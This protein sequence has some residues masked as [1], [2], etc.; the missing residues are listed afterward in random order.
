MCT[1]PA[2]LPPPTHGLPPV[3]HRVLGVT[4]MVGWMASLW[5]WLN[6]QVGYGGSLCLAAAACYAILLMAWHQQRRSTVIVHGML[7]VSCTL[8]VGVAL[9]TGG[10]NSPVLAWIPMLA[11]SALALLRLRR[12]LIW[13]GLLLLI[14]VLMFWAETHSWISPQV[15]QG[16]DGL[17]WAWLIRMQVAASM[18]LAVLLLEGLYREYNHF[19]Q[20][21][22]RELEATQ[23][24]LLKAQTH[25]DE[26]I[27]SVSHELR[28]PM[29]AI[30]GLNQVIRQT[31]AHHPDDVATVTHIQDSTQ[32]LLQVVN[33]ILDYSQLQAGRLSLHMAPLELNRVIENCVDKARHA[34][35]LK[36][37][38]LVVDNQLATPTWVLGD[39]VRLTQIVC[40]TLRNAIAHS[41][42][43]R[44]ALAVQLKSDRLRVDIHDER[45]DMNLIQQLF[46]SDTLTSAQASTDLT[47]QDLSLL[48]AYHLMLLHHG[49]ASA[50]PVTGKGAHFWFDVPVRTTAAPGVAA[51]HAQP[52]S[53]RQARLRVLLV[54]D[55]QTNLVIATLA[56]Q[57][58]FAGCHVVAVQS[59]AA[60][61]EAL[62][63]DRFDVLLVDLRMPQMDGLALARHVRALASPAVSHIPII[64]LTA[65]TDDQERALCLS[66]GMQDVL[67]KPIEEQQLRDSLT[68][69]LAA[70]DANTSH[71]V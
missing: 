32:Q 3:L 65:S 11:L 29:N 16:T 26:F 1:P 28:T 47:A 71:A 30:L 56:L 24:S 42:A 43:G 63:N 9:Q 35:H 6:T 50:E 21:R 52:P 46:S 27:A 8:V 38:T 7:L 12:A 18:M 40:N 45:T 48:I 44:V 31:L 69:V 66:S 70:S 49:R 22:N 67:H 20:S 59:G 60:A 25:K 17:L 4:L 58:C 2:S 33:D 34:A 68:Q 54:D 64:A 19:A 62:M 5:L 13:I 14:Q 41:P 36:E 53:L 15:N 39:R 51:T 10:V 23:A 61:L 57:K 55:N 37:V